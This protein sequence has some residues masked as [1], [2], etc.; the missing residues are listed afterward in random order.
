MVP[1]EART[2][3]SVQGI[4]FDWLACDAHGHV[5]LFTTAGGG[6]APTEFLRDTDAHDRALEVI[7][8]RSRSSLALFAP[9]V[10]PGLVNTWQLAAERGLYA[11]DSDP[12]G[13]PYRLVAAPAVPITVRELPPDVAD[14]ISKLHLPI[15][16]KGHSEISA[17][18]LSTAL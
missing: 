11:F 8:A 5:G 10:S 14:L 7:L 13:G 9:A 17:T 3:E 6:Y 2:A 4:E 12:N 15:N 1:S 18:L 16:F